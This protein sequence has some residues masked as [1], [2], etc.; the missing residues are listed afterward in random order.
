MPSRTLS[1]GSSPWLAVAPDRGATART[2][3]DLVDAART[4][5]VAAFGH[6][7]EFYE[8]RVLRTALAILGNDADA[9]DAAQ[10]VFLRVYRRASWLD[11]NRDPSPWLYKITVN[12]CRDII[13]VRQRHASRSLP[14]AGMRSDLPGPFERLERLERLALIRRGLARLPYK[15]RAAIVLRDMEGLTTRE[16]AKALGTTAATVRS[17]I[18]SGRSKLR[19]YVHSML[20]RHA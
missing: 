14:S 1:I 10:D 18:S 15:E 4:G 12:V 19:K 7:V 16:T 5:D 9:Q 8:R 3:R 20:R 17:Q 2:V 11:P 13:R 6:F